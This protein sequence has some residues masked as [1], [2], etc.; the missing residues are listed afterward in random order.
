MA[1]GLAALTGHIAEPDLLKISDAEKWAAQQLP[2]FNKSGT[3]SWV[4]VQREARQRAQSASETV[5]L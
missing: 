4:D 5:G 3:S 1:R 2:S